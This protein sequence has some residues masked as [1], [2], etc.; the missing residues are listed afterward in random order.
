MRN[1]ELSLL[2]NFT[3]PLRIALIPDSPVPHNS[4]QKIRVDC[5]KKS[6]RPQRGFSPYGSFP[7]AKY[8]PRPLH[9]NVPPWG[10]CLSRASPVG[11]SLQIEQDEWWI[12]YYCRSRNFSMACHNFFGRHI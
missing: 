5:R 6:A 10:I 9:R 1:R 4:T 8:F 2:E 12:T 7:Y 11:R 3:H